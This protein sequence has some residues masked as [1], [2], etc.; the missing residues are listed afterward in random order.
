MNSIRPTIYM[1][2]MYAA[3][4]SVFY[5]A[6]AAGGSGPGAMIPLVLLVAVLLFGIVCITSIYKE[7][8][9][10]LGDDS[11]QAR[12]AGLKRMLAL[13]IAE[14]PF[15]AGFIAFIFLA[16]SMHVK[17]T[18]II[19]V[20]VMIALAFSVVSVTGGY[21]A[22]SILI[23]SNAGLTKGIK[24]GKHMFLQFI[25]AADVID[26][27]YISSLLKEEGETVYPLRARIRAAAAGLILIAAAVI[28]VLIVKN[29][30]SIF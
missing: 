19:F 28:A 4:G 18:Q 27:V 24:T 29:C 2:L 21:G 14:A 20:T 7:A 25:I 11:G 22:A 5:A 15:I 12:A 26:A 30:C 3:A 17:G 6:L 9:N 10:S 8:K 16:L 23:F 13:K 1:V